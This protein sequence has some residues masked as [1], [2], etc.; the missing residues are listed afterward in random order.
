M[1][2]QQP[3]GDIN[4]GIQFLSI[5]Q[6]QPADMLHTYIYTNI[7]PL[8]LL[9]QPAGNTKTHTYTYIHSTPHVAAPTCKN[10]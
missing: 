9:H 10:Y 8:M 1:L 4:I 6:H 2:Q 3:A 7:S 5:L